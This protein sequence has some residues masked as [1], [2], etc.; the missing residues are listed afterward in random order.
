MALKEKYM[1]K[2]VFGNTDFVLEA[3]TGESLL[4]KDIKIYN[5]AT[6][7]ATVYTQK[8]TVGYFRVGGNLGS[9]LHLPIG[10]L[11]HS[12]NLILANEQAAEVLKTY[13]ITG[14]LGVDTALNYNTLTG[15]AGT[16]TNVLQFGSI[17][18]PA[19]MT[20]LAYLRNLG[21]FDGFPIATGEKMTI[22]GVKQA[23]CLVLVEYE[24]YDAADQT[25]DKPNGSKAKEYAFIN[26]GRIAAAA[27]ASGDN[28]Y[29]VQVNPG[30]FPDFPFD[31]DVP[32]NTEIEILGLLA[33]DVVDDRSGGDDMAT[34]YIKLIKE[35][36]VLF[37]E[38]KNGIF[39]RGIIGNTDATAQIARGLSLIGN[40]SNVDGKKPLM[41]DPP[42]VFG[43]GEELSL[44]VTTIAGAAQNLSD[45]AVADLEI[46][47]IERVKLTA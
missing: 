22:T 8:T 14:A 34:S 29:S 39:L 23:N 41:F 21:L 1:V 10:N 26:Y 32:A 42:L 7:Y 19:Q 46:G 28:V 12:H 16:K 24:V 4:V 20:L 5:P 43:A 31:K 36:T 6:N 25:A 44:Y 33:S 37:D 27:T 13:D 11:Q 2:Q 38:D 3:D 15:V 18:S 47:L 35:R 9:H 40:F 17:P 45:L 30:E